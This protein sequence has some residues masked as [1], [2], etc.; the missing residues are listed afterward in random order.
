M[1]VKKRIIDG[2]SDRFSAR[3]ICM[4]RDGSVGTATLRGFDGPGSN[5]V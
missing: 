5:G 3:R 2:V 4:G 1:E